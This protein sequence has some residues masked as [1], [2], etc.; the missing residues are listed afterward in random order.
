MSAYQ[1]VCRFHSAAAFPVRADRLDARED[2]LTHV[3]LPGGHH[4]DIVEVDETPS[5]V[6]GFPAAGYAQRLFAQAAA[7]LDRLRG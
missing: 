2:A 6:E 7:D 4:I 1:G 5:E 3:H